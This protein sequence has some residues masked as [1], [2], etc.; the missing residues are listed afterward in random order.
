VSKREQ[1][2]R[3]TIQVEAADEFALKALYDR[4]PGLTK[5]VVLRA[6]LRIGLAAL[7]DEPGKILTATSPVPSRS[8][9]EGEEFETLTRE[10]WRRKLEKV[11][12]RRRKK[13]KARIEITKTG[14]TTC[15]LVDGK[16][17]AHVNA[18][19][20]LLIAF[21][22]PMAG[23]GVFPKERRAEAI[24]RAGKQAQRF[25]PDPESFPEVTRALEAA[26]DYLLT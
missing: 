12:E 4:A 1:R 9:D 8:G 6:C 16:L 5:S 17:A 3:L 7:L 21:G 15:L 14:K 13:A 24:K 22:K 23:G 26:V 2:L 19:S 18:R 20:G 25:S 11:F 10:G